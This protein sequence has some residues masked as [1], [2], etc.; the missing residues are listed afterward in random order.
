M[1]QI[2]SHK[3]GVILPVRA[4]AGARRDEIGGIHDGM[5]RVSV[6]AAPEKGKANEAIVAMLSKRLGIAKSSILLLSGGKSSRKRFLIHGV[7]RAQL[8]QMFESPSE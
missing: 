6:T 2:E 1:L 5:L 4:H 3:D 8:Q 7:G